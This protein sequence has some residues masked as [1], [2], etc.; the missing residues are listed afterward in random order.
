LPVALSCVDDTYAVV[1]GEPARS[2]CAPLTNPLP[3][4]V[5]VKPP[6]ETDAGAMLARIGMGFCKVTELLAVTEASAA[7]TAATVTEFEPGTEFGA[8]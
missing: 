3:L 8:E 4:R 6:A 2:T 1:T 5:I 7:L